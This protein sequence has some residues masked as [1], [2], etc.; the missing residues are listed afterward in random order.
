VENK[1]PTFPYIKRKW[2]I[3]CNPLLAW[4]PVPSIRKTATGKGFRQDDYK[5]GKVIRNSK[6]R[7]NLAS[8]EL[9]RFD[10]FSNFSIFILSVGKTIYI[11]PD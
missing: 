7:K 1:L 4:L 2:Y 5:P 3:I 10:H 6:F 9:Y 8:T 11:C